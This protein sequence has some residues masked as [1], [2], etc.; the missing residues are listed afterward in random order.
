MLLLGQEPLYR[1]ITIDEGLP[2]NTIY[3]LYQGKDGFIWMGSDKGLIR[4]DGSEFEVY[5]HPDQKKLDIS[6]LQGDSQGTLWCIGFGGEIFK[7]ENDS[8]KLFRDWSDKCSDVPFMMIDEDDM[9][10]LS[11]TDNHVYGFDIKKERWNSLLIDIAADNKLIKPVSSEDGEVIYEVAN[12]PKK[13]FFIKSKK[14]FTNYLLFEN[15][16]ELKIISNPKKIDSNIFLTHFRDRL[17]IEYGLIE[18][19]EREIVQYHSDRVIGD[20]L[21]N[22]VMDIFG[23]KYVATKKGLDIY[24]HK[25]EL[26]EHLFD[27]LEISATLLDSEKGLWVS[28]TNNGVFYIPNNEV[29]SL[30]KTDVGGNKLSSI[31]H[32][33]SL[34]FFGYHNSLVEYAAPPYKERN[35]V[36]FDPSEEGEIEFCYYDEIEDYLFFTNHSKTVKF[37]PKSK[38]SYIAIGTGMKF[39][40]KI[41]D[42]INLYSYSTIGIVKRQ[43]KYPI[44][45]EWGIKENRVKSTLEYSRYR[46]SAFVARSTVK[47]LREKRS[48]INFYDTLSQRAWVSYVDG[49]Y[50]YKEEVETEIKYKGKPIVPT[51]FAMSA[52][53]TLWLSA[54]KGLFAYKD[55]T[56]V[57]HFRGKEGLIATDIN[58]IYAYKDKILAAYNEGIQVL[59]LKDTVVS[60]FNKYDGLYHRGVTGLTVMKDTVY[61]VSP[62]GVAYFPINMPSKN[63][64][65]PKARITKIKALEKEFSTS[66]EIYLPFDESEIEIYMQGIALKSQGDL[67]CE[68]RIKE[69]N[70]KWTQRKGTRTTAVYSGLSEGDYIFEFRVRNEDK[71]ASELQSFRFKVKPPI[72]R[73]WWFRSL[74]ILLGIGILYFV[75][76]R[77]LSRLRLEKSLKS[78]EIKAIKAQMNPHFL[79]NALNSIQDLVLEENFVAANGYLGKFSDL[80]RATLSNS[81]KEFIL[82]IEEMEILQLYLQLEKLR[83]GEDLNVELSIHVEEERQEEIKIPPMLIQPYL[84]N[85]IKHGLL[86]KKGAKHLK[87]SF[88]IEQEQLICIIE[89]NGIGRKQSARIHKRR[90]QKHKSFS[91]D[92][93]EK[94]VDLINQLHRVS[95]E[96]KTTDLLDHEGKVE[97][98]RVCLVFPLNYG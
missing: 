88:E 40:S 76:K 60:T 85:A 45:T 59:S 44:Y 35:K 13:S 37:N 38:R 47:S 75:V 93:N 33:D 29:Q 42:E 3:D 54:A 69:L 6:Y 41:S 96:I 84:E 19:K 9:M 66:N 22:D 27:G 46:D 98:T 97:G 61:T 57:G 8:L 89:D 48:E 83:F 23:L 53:S 70:E 11:S 2:T 81:E 92:A 71:V 14:A 1:N 26:K 55:T 36:F 68:Y 10:L 90:G 43:K 73:T 65:S 24:S 62:S 39:M 28:S 15:E 18:F 51:R 58:F 67:I 78:T 63:L 32:H 64:V 49:L 95:I 56:L 87:L 94:K 79:F 74:A 25:F 16:L 86:H 12:S 31:F 4:Y 17:N 34:L 77:Q 91:T 21:I 52:D 72:Y 30:L 5:I 80:V 7:M 82:L 20:G 50:V